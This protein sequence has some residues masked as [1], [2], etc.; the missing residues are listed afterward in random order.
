[1]PGVLIIIIFELHGYFLLISDLAT[2]A[3]YNCILRKNN[4]KNINARSLLRT[5]IIHLGTHAIVG[6]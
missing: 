3:N 5:C 4:T 6:F 2:L 1:M